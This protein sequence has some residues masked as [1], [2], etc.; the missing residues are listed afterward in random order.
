MYAFVFHHVFKSAAGQVFC[1]HINQIVGF[2]QSVVLD[3][4]GVVDLSK[5]LNLVFQSLLA[6]ELDFLALV[7]K[8]FGC[9]F[10]FGVLVFD[11]VDGCKCASSQ[12]FQ[13]L[14]E[15]TK[16]F[17]GDAAFEFGVEFFGF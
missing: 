12:A 13:G 2:V 8:H 3:Q 9:F 17:V 15:L 6:F 10:D 11:E 5:S 1:N 16:A 4:V 14:V 7:G